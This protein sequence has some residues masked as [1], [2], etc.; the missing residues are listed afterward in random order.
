MSEFI[1]HLAERGLSDEHFWIDEDSERIWFPLYSV[2]SIKLVG[3]QRYSWREGKLRDNG[4][5][6]WTWISDAYKP[7]ACWGLSYLNWSDG[8]ACRSSQRVLVT[9]GIWD[10]IRCR[11]AGYN[12]V[13]V[14][15]ATP[16]KQFI[17]WFK[18]VMQ[19]KELVGVLDNDENNTGLRLQSL[20]SSSIICEEHKDIGEYS[21]KEAKLW[22]SQM[23]N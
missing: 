8:F 3:Y 2:G 1:R 17:A 5:R 14:L 19:G 4:G 11:R 21:T 6:Y 12:A 20:C 18:L 10:A 22:L 16:S 13:A 9:E 7:L 23:L 15:T